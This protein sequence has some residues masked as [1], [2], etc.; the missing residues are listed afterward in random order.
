MSVSVNVLRLY[1]SRQTVCPHVAILEKR[2]CATTLETVFSSFQDTCVTSQH[3]QK[4]S[5]ITSECLGKI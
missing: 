1:R 4:F 3:Y 2:E 5:I